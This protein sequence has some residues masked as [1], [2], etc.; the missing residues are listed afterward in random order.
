MNDKREPDLGS[1]E[2]LRTRTDK[3]LAE[4]IDGRRPGT[5]HSAAVEELRSREA[6]KEAKRQRTPAIW[7]AWL[8]GIGLL[9]ALASL[10]IQISTTTSKAPPVAPLVQS[11]AP[12][13][14][15]TGRVTDAANILT[16]EQELRLST[17]LEQLERTTN[18]QMVVVT[19]P[20]LGGADVATFTR[21]LANSWGIGRKDYDDGVVLL[22]APNERQVRI[23]VG[24]GLEKTLPN[25]VCQ[26]VLREHVMPRFQ[27][28]DIEGGI[29]AGATALIERLN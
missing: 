22:V 9:V 24:Y 23:A 18:H 11:S 17:K 5:G 4:F 21:N 16:P 14:P 8:A 10:G 2:W 3:Q 26:Q 27:K 25:A 12:A 28:G 29:D 7:A 15:L 6:A 19:A 20:T 1:G 13:I